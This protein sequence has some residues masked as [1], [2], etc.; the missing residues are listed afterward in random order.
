MVAIHAPG[1]DA[2]E[3]GPVVALAAEVEVGRAV[4]DGLSQA[5]AVVVRDVGR[6]GRSQRRGAVV[7]R[8]A[9]CVR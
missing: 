2:V 8:D 6:D 3:F 1:L 9:H 7:R 5:V 4:H